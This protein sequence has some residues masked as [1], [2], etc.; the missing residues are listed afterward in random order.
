MPFKKGEPR[1]ANAGRKAGVISKRQMHFKTAQEA[2]AARG[3]DPMDS[4]AELSEDPDKTIRIQAL[5]ELS[6]YMYVQKRAIEL[7]GQDGGPV[8]VE[9][10]HPAVAE[11]RELVKALGNVKPRG[12]S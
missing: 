5:K 7:T 1:P 6:K 10:E 9:Q 2:C 4:W 3:L 12:S 11:L 8:K